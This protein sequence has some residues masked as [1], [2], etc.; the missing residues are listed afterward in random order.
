MSN[1][2]YEVKKGLDI[3]VML[4]KDSGETDMIILPSNEKAISVRSTTELINKLRSYGVSMEEIKNTLVFV[5]QILRTRYHKAGIEDKHPFYEVKKGLHIY[6]L[7]DMDTGK[8]D[9]KILPTNEKEMGVT[10]ITD[11]ANKLRDLGASTLEVH[12]ALDFTHKQLHVGY[13]R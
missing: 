13:R 9:V 4:S 7:R 6:V 8:T 3:C 5:D 1:P 10:S 12:Y 11:L 2:Y